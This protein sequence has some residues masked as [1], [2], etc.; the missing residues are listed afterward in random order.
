MR[1]GGRFRSR[2]G[3]HGEE[4]PGDGAA[5]GGGLQR[6]EAAVEADDDGEEAGDVGE[7]GSG[8]DEV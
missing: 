5:V 4:E 8:E 1:S 7:E 6:A 2:V 3:D